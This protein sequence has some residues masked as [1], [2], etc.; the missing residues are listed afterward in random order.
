[1]KPDE[2]RKANGKCPKCGDKVTVGVMHR[3]EELADRPEGALPQG[4]PPFKSIIPLGEI[5]GE[6]EGVGANSKRVA[7]KYM[8]MLTTFGDEYTILTK[9]PIEDIKNTSK[10]LADAIR[11]MRAGELDINPGYD[12]E[13]G[14]VSIF[15]KEERER[16]SGQKSL[17]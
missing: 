15:T 3:V 16:L 10:I 12:G 8:H 7:Q 4:M 14:K 5:I 17:F 9:T 13:Y 1:M 11:K 2:T 6:V